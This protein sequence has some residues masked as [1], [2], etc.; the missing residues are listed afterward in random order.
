MKEKKKINKSNHSVPNLERALKILELLAKHPEGLNIT[1]ISNLLDIPKN[2]TFRITSTLQ[3]YGYPHR[4][5]G[6]ALV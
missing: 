2:R 3:S 1:Q 4:A 5:G 6:P